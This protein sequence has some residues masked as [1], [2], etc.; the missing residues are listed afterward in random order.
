MPV[1]TPKDLTQ[2]LK[3]GKIEPVYFLFGPEAYLRDEAA[4]AIAD[5]ALRNTL[6]REFNESSFNLLTDD[7]GSAI[8][9]A[10]QLRQIQADDPSQPI[11]VG[12]LER[13]E[14]MAISASPGTP[15]RPR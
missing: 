11:D 13:V 14:P 3:Q 5:E 7:V 15:A 1:R 8:A 2:S 4:R 6:L 10:E 12:R 9:I